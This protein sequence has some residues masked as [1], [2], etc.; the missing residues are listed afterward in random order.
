MCVASDPGINQN[1]R[2]QLFC[3]T[4][5]SIECLL[6]GAFFDSFEQKLGKYDKAS[7]ERTF[8]EQEQESVRK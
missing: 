1:L 2:G 7:W 4:Q 5:S 8:E 3:G 6:I